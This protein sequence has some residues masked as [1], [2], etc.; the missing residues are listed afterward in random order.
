MLKGQN[1][2]LTRTITDFS[3]KK[4][5]GMNEAGKDLRKRS[6]L[7]YFKD[8]HYHQK[9]NLPF[10]YEIIPLNKFSRAPDC[11]I[12]I[13]GY[14]RI[15]PGVFEYTGSLNVNSIRPRTKTSTVFVRKQPNLEVT[16][17]PFFIDSLSGQIQRVTSFKIHLTSSQNKNLIIEQKRMLSPLH[18]SILS[19]GKWV[20][21][22]IFK[23]G[24]YKITHSMMAE[25]GFPEPM[26]PRVYG[27][28]GKMIPV[29]NSQQRDTGL[30]E[31]PILMED[32][33][34]G[35][36]NDGDYFLFYG[37][38]P[39]IWN[40]DSTSGMFLHTLNLY[41]E[42]SYYFLTSGTDEGA[43]IT[44]SIPPSGNIDREVRVFTQNY[45][46]EEQKENL[47]RSGT[48]W[49]EP[50]SSLSSTTLSF[51][52]PSIETASTGKLKIRLAARAPINTLF[53]LSENGNSL[54]SISVGNVNM[55]SYTSDYA[56][57]QVSYTDFQPSDNQVNLEISVQN[58]SSSDSK[59]WLD[60][61]D[62]NVRE[63][64]IFN[65]TQL[66]FKDPFSVAAGT[67]SR[68]HIKDAPE[69][70]LI[71][72]VSQIHY[73]KMLPTS[74]DGNGLSFLVKTDSL[75][76]FIAF[77]PQEALVPDFL[78]DAVKNQDLRA[79]RDQDMIIV[80]AV[81]FLEEANRLAS[82]H[83][84]HD[85][86]STT[87]VTT[88]QV[89]NEYSSG[90]RDPG[91]IRD[92]MK[93]LY[94]NSSPDHLP[95]YLLLFGDGSFNN[96]SLNDN[97]A[98]FIP[99]FQSWNSLSP[100]QSYITD[101]FFG[102]LDPSEG[103]AIGLVDLG[104]GRFPVNT[105]EEAK[106][107]TD[108]TIAYY[109]TVS[110]GLWR[111]RLCF[112][113]DDEDN[114]IHMRDANTLCNYLNVNYPGFNL[115]KIFLDAY[116]QVSSP[117]GESYPE[118]NN[119]IHQAIQDG[120]LIFNY[121][122]HGSEHGL[123]HED[124]L[125]M[126]DISSW[127]NSKKLPLFI[128][129]TCEFSRF[130]DINQDLYGNF[131]RK[132]SAGEEVLLQPNGGGIALLSTTRLVYSSPN[133]ILNQNFYKHIFEKGSDGKKMGLGEVLRL[134]KNESGS[135]IN[136]RNFT[137][138]GDPALILAYPEPSATIDSINRLEISAFSDTIKG[139]EQMSFS[140]HM[141]TIQ[142]PKSEKGTIF[143]TV[144]GKSSFLQTLS[145]DG[146]PV[147]DFEVRNK[148]LYKGK[149]GVE[150][151]KFNF[152]FIVPKDIS[153]QPGNGKISFYFENRKEQLEGSGYYE[154]FM[155]GGIS[156]SAQPD[157]KGPEIQLYFND[158]Y[159]TP[160]G[161]TDPNPVIFAH[162]F[163]ESG[164]N[165]LG[166]GIGHDIV[167][168]LDSD[169]NNPF[170]LNNYYESDLNSY[171]SGTIRYPLYNLQEGPHNLSLKVWDIFNNSA[172]SQI[173]FTV[174]NGDA[175]VL[176]NLYNYPNPFQNETFIKL[177]HNL[178][179][180]ELEVAIRIF[181]MNG[182]IIKL[183]KNRYYSPGYVLG[184]I[185]WDGTDEGGQRVGAG[186]YIFKVDIITP[187]GNLKEIN[188]KM[189]KLN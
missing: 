173:N 66:S 65:G 99:T 39:L 46:H 62:L 145:N 189:I 94:D 36:F 4:R 70:T 100:T 163:D 152:S 124:I 43:I 44:T 52:L 164:I 95:K 128:T 7:L 87:V 126:N 122:G 185:Q 129:A 158:T 90:A 180:E 181:D 147:M 49:F 23:T 121:T 168:I 33:G 139:L 75:H 176:K 107:I 182:R 28:G 41:D 96:F 130:D 3:I 11:K 40:F 35:T 106:I 26:H 116:T 98:N 171:Q 45:Y 63:N 24:V 155:I 132:V 151:G 186:F 47:I 6:Y 61:V 1:I 89:F 74:P 159:F 18:H 77:N 105:V 30:L 20:K 86:L 183:I 178:P 118:V 162:V 17:N 34:D 21:I 143:A 137:L 179:D 19:N 111:N 88:D 97:N 37:Q 109:D 108:K 50:I 31:I 92:F 2:T 82:F 177:E 135:G 56:K 114:N 42:K 140:G 136:K 161:I 165:T 10:F 16:I 84:E 187:D 103:G 54:T 131:I 166:T 174:V 115:E 13:T 134:T 188:G 80:T 59:Y 149:A 64:L 167:A 150:N 85:R 73:C 55:A 154:N 48:Q 91:A 51:T 153:F 53:S 93:M 133:F 184:P 32:G 15:D 9:D 22:G 157:N 148:I 81:D 170:I 104:I 8:C 146:T 123:A 76:K 102:L 160:G 5:S 68:F 29:M 67:L 58:N 156:G 72:D 57:A 120:I 38:G 117:S 14:K 141:D 25:I 112:V 27:N 12:E 113:G 60:Y 69:G 79:V 110:Y 119:A 144:Y 78:P 127:T 101:D 71:W 83:M 138:L 175:L 172:E 169:K 125:N 142:N